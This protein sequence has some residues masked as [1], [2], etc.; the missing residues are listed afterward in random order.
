MFFDSVILLFNLWFLSFKSSLCFC[1][2]NNNNNNNNSI[3]Y[4]NNGY[5][6]NDTNNNNDSVAVIIV[7]VVTMIIIT[8]RITIII[9]IITVI[10][11]HLMLDLFEIEFHNFSVYNISDITSRVTVLKSLR[12]FIFS[13]IFY[14]IFLILLF[15]INILN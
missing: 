15:N 4:N 2:F 12:N 1:C 13:S 8:I 11:H 7:T 6:D 9:I 10:I 3:N 14:I 5:N